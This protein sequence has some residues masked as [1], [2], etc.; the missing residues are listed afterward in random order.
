MHTGEKVTGWCTRGVSLR[1]G[2]SVMSELKTRALLRLMQEVANVV[3]WLKDC[4]KRRKTPITS[5]IHTK[6]KLFFDYAFL[7]S[8]NK[9][10]LTFFESSTCTL[11]LAGSI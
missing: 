2:A 11:E 3:I 9:T 7:T 10:R 8:I 1:H 6:T 5:Q 4:S